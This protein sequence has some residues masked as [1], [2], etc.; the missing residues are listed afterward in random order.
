M[1]PP[2]DRARQE[3]QDKLSLEI[4]QAIADLRRTRAERDRLAAISV[5]VADTPDGAVAVRKSIL[6][7]NEAL[8]RLRDILSAFDEFNNLGLHSDL[9]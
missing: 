5:D 2:N 6:L 4:E 9:H 7:H 8:Q 1:V 3:T